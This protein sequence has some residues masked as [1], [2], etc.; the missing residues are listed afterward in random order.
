MRS[1]PT[2]SE[3]EL[4]RLIHALDEPLQGP[5]RVALRAL[6]R[7]IEG[8]SRLPLPG[9]E[10][11]DVL[12]ERI[13]ELSGESTSLRAALC[14][15]E[16][17]RARTDRLMHA[18]LR[19]SNTP[20]GSRFFDDLVENLATAL[21]VRYALVGE[22]NP[23]AEGWV[24]ALSFWTGEGF[25]DIFSYAL[26][27]SPCENTIGRRLCYVPQGASARFPR[28][29]LLAEYG[30]EGYLGVS[31]VGSGG[32][33][34][35]LL[36][37]LDT[38]PIS[39][40]N[41]VS[42]VS[43]FAARAGAELERLH[44]ERSIRVAQS[45]AKSALLAKTQFLAS[46]SHEL[47]TPMNG[48]IGMTGLLLDTDLDDE[49]RDYCRV[50]RESSEALLTM[51]NGILDFSRAESGD[52]ALESIEF[53]LVSVIEDVIELYAS[54]AHSKGLELIH[55]VDPELPQIVRGDPGRLRQVLG[56]LLENAV[57]FTERGEVVVDARPDSALASEHDTVGIRIEVRDTGCGIPED[58][59][60]RLFGTFER[61]DGSLTQRQ[62]GTGL[63]L[64]LAKRLVELM[65]GEIG[66]RSEKSR[67]S[68]FW[69]TVKCDRSEKPAPLPRGLLSAA[70]SGRRVLCVDDSRIQRVFLQRRLIAWGLEVDVAES[71]EAALARLLDAAQRDAR[72]DLLLLDA[73]LSDLS[74]EAVVRRMSSDPR[75]G[76]VATVLVHPTGGGVDERTERAD[77]DAT[78]VRGTI[79]KPIREHLLHELV[80]AALQ[81]AA[82]SPQ[83]VGSS[84]RGRRVLLLEDNV[85]DQ[86]V[87]ARLFERLGC[88]VDVVAS[89]DEAV[90]AVDTVGYDCVVVDCAMPGAAMSGYET[91]QA[92]RARE[93]GT[94]PPTTILAMV[95]DV[96]TDDARWRDFGMN[97]SIC[98][99]IEYDELERVLA[100]WN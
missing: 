45:A 12:E 19:G 96:G 81:G 15:A 63:G 88:R 25:S 32:R 52:L 39:D 99:P 41:A 59:Q 77:A 57:K 55:F 37:A 33:P 69:F 64:A 70:M 43:I 44:A 1:K 2:Q 72:Y 9:G 97:D 75:I 38:E 46:M 91:A 20:F 92:I 80:V 21:G 47:R 13:R 84:V 27:G 14:A 93:N 85:V 76:E 73:A 90:E 17:D 8:T 3:R 4:L 36:A 61:G 29:T 30:I 18:I 48:I 78:A 68:T 42:V 56:H 74:A 6:V 95:P 62:R 89:G 50:V 71:G 31:I 86:R 24:D 16:E 35:G 100:K 60:E 11:P 65:H 22:L 23:S 5:F 53:S 67:G 83:R 49:Q 58:R 7:E 82:P 26:S 34:V 98:K 51:V 28:D 10:A 54:E 40:R 87:I 94:A 66:V 79:G